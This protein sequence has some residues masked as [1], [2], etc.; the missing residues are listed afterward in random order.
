MKKM[1]ELVFY[2]K[3]K[4]EKCSALISIQRAFIFLIPIFT[5]GAMALAL[6]NFPIT[7][8]R[9]F[10][11]NALNGHLYKFLS[12]VYIVTY[13]FA[14]LYLVIMV[15]YHESSTITSHNYTKMFA[16]LT[17][18]VCYFAFLGADIFDE[19]FKLLQYTRMA[20][21]FP[22]LIVSLVATHIFF[23]FFNFFNR[24]YHRFTSTF[25]S[26]LNALFSILFCILIFAL[27]SELIGMIP[28]INNFNDLILYI[29]KNTF[30]R[31]SAEGASFVDGLLVILIESLLWFFGIH[32]GNVVDSILT[33]SDSVFATQYGQIMTKPFIDVFVLMGGCGTV[34]CFIIAIALCSKNIKRRRVCKLSCIPVIF[35]I[36]E[37]LVFGIPLA[38]N[39][40]YA[41]PFVL[42][43]LAVYSIAYAATAAGLVPQIINTD[44][45]WTTPVF[46]SGYQATGSIRG[47]VFQLLLIA[48]GVLIYLPFVRLD[49][50]ISKECE[51]IAIDRMTDI[52]HDLEAQGLPYKLSKQNIIFRIYENSVAEKLQ[53]DI[54][55]EMIK[56]HYQ[57][58]IENGK[59]IS[60][61]ALLRFSYPDEKFMYPPL[62]VGIA[63]NNDMFEPLTKAIVKRSLIDLQKFQKS[64]PD[65]KIAINVKLD[66]LMENTFREWLISSVK[67]SGITP[68]TFSVELNEDAK[69][70][71]YDN[72]VLPFDELKNAG[73]GIMMDDFAMGHT[74]ISILQKSCFDYVKIDGKLIK[75]L[76]NERCQRIVSSVINLGKD[77]HFNVV[78]EYVETE[79]QRDTLLKMGCGIFQGYLYSRPV[80]DNELISLLDKQW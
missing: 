48:I 76:D 65:F 49:D 51:Q 1:P 68:N 28:G 38:L 29:F 7:V 27:L 64:R 16:V 24:S 33:S 77:L 6:Q 54:E 55:H 67:S 44:I 11:A 80:P 79:K 75:E 40:I 2:L 22:A 15:A 43:P 66:L 31:G 8:I 37:L 60:A 42:T 74:S 35:N 45:I 30:N 70:S 39:P 47:S 57:P 56:L 4:Y 14:A 52:C 69:I 25:T 17:S 73:I 19:S 61:E 62:V 36:N 46:L 23:A 59:M 21:V 26:A 50:K 58:L 34:I 71:D 5:I 41:I 3:T 10:I 63:M 78:A 20:N 13:E 32:G 72:F 12:T 18:V 9:E 53:S